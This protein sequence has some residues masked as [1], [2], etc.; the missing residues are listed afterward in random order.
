MNVEFCGDEAGATTFPA[1][2][3]TDKNGEIVTILKRETADSNRLQ[4]G[5]T[6]FV[7]KC[8][9]IDTMVADGREGY[10]IQTVIEALYKSA[11]KGESVLI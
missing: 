9:G 7:D 3:Y 6:A 4:K 11:E 8:L 5:I 1:H 2:V 10:L